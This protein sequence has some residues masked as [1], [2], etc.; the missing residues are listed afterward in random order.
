VKN[1]GRAH[2]SQHLTPPTSRVSL[3]SPIALPIDWTFQ[4]LSSCSKTSAYPYPKGREPKKKFF[5]KLD[6]VFFIEFKKPLFIR[7]IITYV[8][9]R[10]NANIGYALNC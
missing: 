5:M 9:K 7:L 10:Q 8:S 6:L 2:S 1:H 4:I 3:T